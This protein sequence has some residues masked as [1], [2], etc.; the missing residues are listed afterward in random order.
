MKE[1]AQ[2]FVG[3]HDFRHFCKLDVVNVKTFTRNILSFDIE[4]V[5][6]HSR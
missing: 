4:P 1:A 3:E 5:N 6:E 2:K